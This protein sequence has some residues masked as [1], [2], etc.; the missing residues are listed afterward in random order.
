MTRQWWAKTDSVSALPKIHDLLEG[1]ML[2]L[3]SFDFNTFILKIYLQ[4]PFLLG[5]LSRVNLLTIRS[6]ILVIEIS[7]K[8]KLYMTLEV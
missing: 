7:Y 4:F 8:Q 2:Q 6:V 1:Q 5:E 3:K